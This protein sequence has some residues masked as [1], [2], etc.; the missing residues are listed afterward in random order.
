MENVIKIAKKLQKI[1]KKLYIVWGYNRDILLWLEKWDIDLTTDATSDEMKK[2]LKVVWE[3][4]KKYGTLIISEW[5]E[6]FEITTFREDIWSINNRKPVEVVFTND[7]KKDAQRRDFTMNAIYFDVLEE[8][9]IDPVWWMLDLENKK[10]NFIGNTQDRIDEDALRILR[11]IRFKNKYNLEAKNKD[12]EIIK[13]NIALL[14]NISTERIREELDKILLN[15]NNVSALEDLKEIGFLKA[16]MP[17][18]NNLEKAPWWKTSHTEWN[19]WVH[20]MMVIEELNKLNITDISLYYTVLYHDTWKVDTFILNEE[21]NYSYPNHAD[22]SLNYFVEESKNLTF[23]NKE[24]KRI[25]YLIA[26]HDKIYRLQKMDKVEV[27]KFVMSEYIEDL[28]ILMKVDSFWKMPVDKEK[29]KTRI[30]FINKL[31]KASNEAKLL[32]WKD[33]IKKYPKLKWRQ[34]WEKLEQENN[35]ILEKIE[36]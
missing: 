9:Y 35:K 5:W 27:I 23:S 29:F 8:K 28:L 26:N 16:F 12:F 34:I 31:I 13:Q 24:L 6:V 21:D 36:I 7:I 2:I 19:V 32:T 4:W 18:I 3:V 15:K 1:W 14:K 22:Y 20:T 30:D 33:I 25:K 10:I 17:S 11:F